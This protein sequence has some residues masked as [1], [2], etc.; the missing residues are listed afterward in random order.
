MRR[1]L[2]AA[3]MSHFTGTHRR[4]STDSEAQREPA[5]QGRAGRL[6][7]AGE[8]RPLGR[9]EC[10]P[11]LR[12]RRQ[13]RRPNRGDRERRLQ[14]GRFSGSPGTADGRAWHVSAP[15]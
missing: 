2:R 8:E 9:D 10:P 5:R 1:L 15:G 11:R 13:E 6:G 14:E 3:E 4:L 7:R 12:E